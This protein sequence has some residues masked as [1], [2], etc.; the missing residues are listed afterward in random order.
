MRKFND[1]RTDKQMDKSDFIG[2]FPTKSRVQNTKILY[3]S[4]YSEMNKI[5]VP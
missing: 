5:G 4:L 1:G 3:G 2:R